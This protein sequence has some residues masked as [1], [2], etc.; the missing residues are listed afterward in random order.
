M[1]YLDEIIAVNQGEGHGGV[2]LSWPPI[3]FGFLRRLA[4]RLNSALWSAENDH[5]A[6]ERARL[7]SPWPA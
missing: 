3:F 7:N 5:R 4:G 2:N 1:R 6:A